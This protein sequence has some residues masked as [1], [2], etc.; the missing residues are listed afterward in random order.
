MAIGE[1]LRGGRSK[2]TVCTHRWLRCTFPDNVPGPKPHSHSLCRMHCLFE[3]S[4]RI[5]GPSFHVSTRLR[6][7][8]FWPILLDFALVYALQFIPVQTSPVPTCPDP[9]ISATRPT[10]SCPIR[11]T[12]GQITEFPP[13]VLGFG[14][15]AGY[16]TRV[17]AP[18]CL[19]ALLGAVAGLGPTVHGQAVG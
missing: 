15:L 7:V 2:T 5:L 14:R 1:N 3:D 6:T 9:S 19:L 16:L 11:S 10:S 18:G 13:F 12:F 4:G 17:F 8:F